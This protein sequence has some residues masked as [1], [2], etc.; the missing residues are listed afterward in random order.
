MIKNLCN[1]YIPLT[2]QYRKYQPSNHLETLH[3]TLVNNGNEW[4]KTSKRILYKETST[5]WED[6]SLTGSIFNVKH[7]R[8]K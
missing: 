7:K 3:I 6:T 5:V 4:V 1:L 2:L 8:K